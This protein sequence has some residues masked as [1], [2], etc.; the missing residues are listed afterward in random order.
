MA[1]LREQC[2]HAFRHGDKEI[3]QQLLP[4]LSQPYMIVD[5]DS[6]DM[7]LIHHAAKHGWDD[8]CQILVEEYD[9]DPLVFDREGAY[10][11]HW[12][13]A[14]GSVPTVEYLLLLDDVL[15][16]VNDK[17]VNGDTPL[18]S[19]CA[20]ARLPVIE[21]LLSQPDVSITETDN[22]GRTPIERLTKFNYAVLAEFSKRGMDGDTDIF[23]QPYFN[24]FMAGNTEAGKSTLTATMEELAQEIPSQHGH[25]SGIKSHTA[26]V[27]PTQC[28][29]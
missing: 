11:L 16:R 22:H 7:S 2:V 27:S 5:Y 24:V 3:A 25:V 26:G 6:W 20:F 4:K 28:T 14:V 18:H 23:V 15:M 19:A 8:I 29:G 13:C 1:D 9:C 17:D 10:P 21:F 12:A